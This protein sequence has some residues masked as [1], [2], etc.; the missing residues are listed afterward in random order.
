MTTR[1]SAPQFGWML[2]AGASAIGLLAIAEV[3]PWWIGMIIASL[4]LSFATGLHNG[5]STRVRTYI[6]TFVAVMLMGLLLSQLTR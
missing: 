3:I 6:I 1:Y 4:L 5:Q 2:V